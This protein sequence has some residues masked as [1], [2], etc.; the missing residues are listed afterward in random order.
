M[1]VLTPDAEKL[2]D[3]QGHQLI[4]GEEKDHRD[5]GK[6]QNHD[7]RDH[8]LATRRPSH[9]RRLRPYLL[10]EGKR[11]GGFR[12]HMPLCFRKP[13]GL[14]GCS[15]WPGDAAAW[16]RSAPREH[17]FAHAFRTR[18]AGFPASRVACL[19]RILKD[20]SRHM[21]VPKICLLTTP[22]TDDHPI[23]PVWIF[24]HI[25]SPGRRM[26]PRA[27]NLAFDRALCA[28]FAGLRPAPL[29]NQ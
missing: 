27:R 13:K 10:Q 8:G 17:I 24:L 15:R 5:G 20:D 21:Q 3:T 9:L 26:Q 7:R 28:L 29:T 11:I 14:L 18:K 22:R 16:Y 23:V 25:A 19:I 12:R 2:L 6:N 4:G 1:P